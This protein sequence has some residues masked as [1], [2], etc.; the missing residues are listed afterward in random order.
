MGDV[1]SLV[2]RID[3]EKIAG[4]WQGAVFPFLR[5][6]GLHIGGMHNAFG[7]DGALYLGETVRGWMPTEGNE[8]IQRIVWNGESPVEIY[9][10][11]LTDRGFALT[12][13]VPM[14]DA[15]G[16]ARSFQVRRFQYNYHPLDGSLRI[17]QADVPVT[18]ARLAPDGKSAELELL[19][20]QPTFVY[21]IT[22]AKTVASRAGQALLNPSAFYTLNRT[23]SGATIA[24]PS[25]IVAAAASTAL[26]PGDAARGAEVF[27]LNCMVCHGPDGKGSA[28]AGTPD[29]TKPGGP[30][31]K[32]D[33]ELI[34]V[35]TNGKL[36]T[37]PAVTPMPPWGNVL[38]PQ[39]IRDVLAYLRAT[40]QPPSAP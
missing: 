23:K 21:E 17:N 7:P 13:T 35:I 37:P 29:Y 36:P 22:V 31:S 25:R 28:Q 15:A 39:S 30:L 18:S 11:R 10:L 5:G 9:T 26:Q 40:F 3:L 8:G 4:A 16:D 24:G 34:G 20:V 27:R 1:S 32:S 12:F 2:V 33:A 6:Q 38:P 19:E 14:G